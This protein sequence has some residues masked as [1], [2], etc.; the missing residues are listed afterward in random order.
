MQGNFLI[1][2]YVLYIIAR[3]SRNDNC[4]VE[5]EEK[6]FS[7]WRVELMRNAKCKKWQRISRGYFCVVNDCLAQSE[8]KMQN[9][10][11]KMMVSLRDE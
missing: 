10:E 6:L 1:F 3:F 11:C 7:E 2:A 4:F 9:A 5:S 8:C